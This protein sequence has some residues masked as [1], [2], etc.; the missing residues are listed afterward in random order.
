MGRN[1]FSEREI[2]IIG[3]LLGRKMAGNRNQQKMVRHTLRTVFD[4]NISDFNVQG[5]A[6]GP[7][8]L[9]ECIRRGVIHVLDDAT[10]ETMKARYAERKERDE[11]LRQAEAVADGEMVDWQEVQRQWDEYYNT[12]H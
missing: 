2:T 12:E 6:F 1:K 5:K 3:K 10:I 11:T 7:T 8:E 4:F 9:K